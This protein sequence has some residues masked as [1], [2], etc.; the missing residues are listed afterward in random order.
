MSAL[1]RAGDPDY[2]YVTGL[3]GLLKIERDTPIS[4]G[5]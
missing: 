4:R 5:S 2:N 1:R 3:G